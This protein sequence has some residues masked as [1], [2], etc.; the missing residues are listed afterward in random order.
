MSTLKNIIALAALT[1]L[2]FSSV[3]PAVAADKIKVAGS[4][5]SVFDNYI[6]EPCFLMGMLA[7]KMTKTNKIGV[8]RI[9]PMRYGTA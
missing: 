2:P 6:H 5:F 4:N 3:S 1:L 8:G 9:K 7:G